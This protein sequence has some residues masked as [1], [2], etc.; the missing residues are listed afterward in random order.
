MV[1]CDVHRVAKK[2]IEI[3]A[4]LAMVDID[5]A[6]RLNYIIFGDLTLKRQ[7]RGY[8]TRDGT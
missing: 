2:R 7:K 1:D 3:E 4:N 6:A 8:E 5:M